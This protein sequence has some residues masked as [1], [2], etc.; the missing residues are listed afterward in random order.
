M[1]TLLRRRRSY[2]VRRGGARA[3]N[4][5]PTS[6]ARR[7]SSRRHGGRPA[8]R[9]E[10]LPTTIPLADHEVILTFDDGPDA[11]YTPPVL[12]ALA[13]QCVR[14]TF[15]VIGRNSRGAAGARAA[16]ARRRAHDRP[17]HLHPS[18][19]DAALHERRCRRAPTF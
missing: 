19:A 8:G 10:N 14:A 16:R 4:A 2:R 1:R 13:E 15:F 6:S 12:E 3:P 17:P 11:D 9:A 18:P 7:G 5:G